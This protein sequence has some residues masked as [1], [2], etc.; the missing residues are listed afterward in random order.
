MQGIWSNEDLDH[1][2]GGYGTFVVARKGTDIDDALESLQRWKDNVYVSEITSPR[3]NKVHYTSV[4]AGPYFLL[5]NL[6][7]GSIEDF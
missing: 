1:I 5:L 3:R 4:E 6:D 2:L 7:R